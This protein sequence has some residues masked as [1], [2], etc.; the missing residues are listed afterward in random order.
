[1][2]VAYDD[3]IVPESDPY[4]EIYRVY[5]DA[6][7]PWKISTTLVLSL[8]SLT[9]DEPT[10]MRPLNRAVDPD[11]LECHVQGQNRGAELTFEFHGHRV[12]V[13]DDGRITF[14]PLGEGEPNRG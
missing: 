4:S 13:R 1:M 10:E 8:Q 9:K 11:V 7:S 5:H 14:S 2:T 6:D 12:T 3:T